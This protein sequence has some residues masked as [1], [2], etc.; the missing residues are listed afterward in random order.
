MGIKNN[1]LRNGTKASDSRLDR[2]IQFDERS[3]NYPIAALRATSYK[4]RSY[5]WRCN[6]KFDQGR[7]GSCVGF[8]L[9]HELAARP[10]EVAGLTARFLKEKI[11]WE[12]Q[13]ID[14]WKGGAYPGAFPFYEGTSVLA[15]IKVVHKL[16]FIEAYRWAFNTNDVLYGLGHN[17]PAV[18]GV[19]WYSNMQFPNAEG[20]IRPTGAL[21]GGH[22]ILVK[23]IDI[24][25]GF[26]TMQNS[27]G[28]RWGINGDCRMGFDDFDKLLHEDGECSFLIK[29]KTVPVPQT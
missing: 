23:A 28:A 17:G 22:C 29:R 12:A 25:S 2:L 20:F 5:T 26:V 3:R 15:G 18:I 10:S 19:N 13:K 8:G 4:L 21:V 27:W 24:N 6:A 11:Y 7:E 16:G 9:G 1:T 14:P